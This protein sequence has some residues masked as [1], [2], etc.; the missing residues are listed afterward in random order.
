MFT[1]GADSDTKEHR[2]H[3]PRQHCLGQLSGFCGLRHSFQSF[4]PIAQAV[5]EICAARL[6]CDFARD[7]VA[8]GQ[9]VCFNFPKE[10]VPAVLFLPAGE[11]QKRLANIERLAA[12]LSTAG[13]D[14]S[15]LLI[16]FGG[17]I[18]GDACGFLAAIYMRGIPYIQVPTTLLAQ[19]DSS[20]G[21]KTA[22][23]LATGKNLIGS[24]HHPLAVLADVEL[25]KTLPE[26]ELARGPV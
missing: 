7:M 26:R 21:G 23:N 5:S 3:N 1:H 18:V 22:V 15:S 19:V 8:L 25:L 9:A 17:G 4:G 6:H 2:A 14:R 10:H 13:A 12:E 20:V 16:A 24:F 11:Q